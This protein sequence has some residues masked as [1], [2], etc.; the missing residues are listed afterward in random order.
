MFAVLP[1]LVLINFF[2]VTIVRY[3]RTPFSYSSL[4]SQFLEN[5]KQ[6]WGTTAFHIGIG[7][8]L[9]GHL[10]GLMI[11]AQVLAWNSRANSA[12]TGS[13][14]VC[15][16]AWSSR[17]SC[18][19][20]VTVSGIVRT[21]ATSELRSVGSTGRAT[22]VNTADLVEPR[23]ARYA[24]LALGRTDEAPGDVEFALRVERD[25]RPAAPPRGNKAWG[26][27]AY[28]VQVRVPPS[29]EPSWGW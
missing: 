4:S 18:L 15:T 14:R 24:E 12:G 10:I 9:L 6:F 1:Y 20:G 22:S 13:S 3:R 19:S 21:V 23:S 5:R 2:L 7:G 26:L 17:V 16:A 29:R 11:P 28:L 27:L 8:V 25:G